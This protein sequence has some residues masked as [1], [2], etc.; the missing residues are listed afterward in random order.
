MAVST[1]RA[2]SY[3]VEAALAVGFIYFVLGGSSW[4]PLGWAAFCVFAVAVV[5]VNVLH[6]AERLSADEYWRFKNGL[7]VLC[8]LALFVGAAWRGSVLL[9]GTALLMG[10]FWLDDRRIHRQLERD[11]RRRP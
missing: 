8:V 1:R 11:Q 6:N 7:A 9:L 5:V 2:S 3:I 10:Y 4:P